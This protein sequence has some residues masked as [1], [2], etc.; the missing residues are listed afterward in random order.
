[1][2]DEQQTIRVIDVEPAIKRAYYELK[3]EREHFSPKHVAERIDVP[4]SFV[5]R[6]AFIR[7]VFGLT[8]YM[9][10]IKI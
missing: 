4:A 5:Y 8:D 7:A 1:M 6:N 3:A 9:P 2:N 10:N